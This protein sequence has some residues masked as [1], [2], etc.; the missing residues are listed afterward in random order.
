[1]AGGPSAAMSDKAEL[2]CAC[3]C[4]SAGESRPSASGH[5]LG[6]PPLRRRASKMTWQGEFGEWFV[7]GIPDRN[8]GPDRWAGSA[9]LKGSNVVVLPRLGRCQP[10]STGLSAQG[11]LAPFRGHRPSG[12]GRSPGSADLQLLPGRGRAPA[13]SATGPPL[14]DRR[15]VPRS[16]TRP[17]RR[18]PRPAR[19]V[20]VR[21]PR[22]SERPRT[23]VSAGLPAG[24]RRP[25]GHGSNTA[26]TG[27]RAPGRQVEKGGADGQAIVG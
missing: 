2:N 4:T 11:R 13:G 20:I 23:Q 15:R 8:G 24:R 14:A 7:F 21:S 12:C 27:R 17:P 1:M 26:A 9:S 18:R 10:S 6:G 19:T 25:A 16:I 5:D 22:T 3:C